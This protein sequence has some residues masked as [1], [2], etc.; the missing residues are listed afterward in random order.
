MLTTLRLS[1]R[2]H[3][4]PRHLCSFHRFLALVSR[5]LRLPPLR[6]CRTLGGASGGGRQWTRAVHSTLFRCDPAVIRS[7][8]GAAMGRRW[9]DSA[10]PHHLVSRG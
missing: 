4:H 3:G 6:R 8:G 5:L 9:F 1:R 7:G 10:A 2:H